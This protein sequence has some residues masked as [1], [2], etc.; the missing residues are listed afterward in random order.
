MLC[1]ATTVTP[2]LLATSP[3]GLRI[4][5]ELLPLPEPLL[6]PVLPLLPLPPEL[7]DPPTLPLPELPLAL[8][9]LPLEP[10]PEPPPLPA[11]GPD[12]P[13]VLLPLSPV[14]TPLEPVPAPLALLDPVVAVPDEPMLPSGS[15]PE[16]D[17]SDDELHAAAAA[18]E[19][20]RNATERTDVMMATPSAGRRRALEARRTER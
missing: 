4:L 9:E 1:A 15:R 11:L 13:P 16:F 18:N 2:E 5:S 12:D 3:G 10:A 17:G 7:P 20:A 8:P 6:L 19:R 14:L